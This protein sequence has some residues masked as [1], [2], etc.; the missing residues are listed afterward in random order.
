[1]TDL[2]WN[3]NV[4]LPASLTKA[5]EEYKAAYKVAKALRLSFEASVIEAVEDK[6]D[7]D[8]TLVFSY[9]FGKLG[10]AIAP[11]REGKPKAK[12]QAQLSLGDLI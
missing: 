4:S 2:N 9:N 12:S 3:N 8:K 5:Y 7:A 1:M 6:L 11:K 10:I